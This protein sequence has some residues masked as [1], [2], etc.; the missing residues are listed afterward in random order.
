MTSDPKPFSLESAPAAGHGSLDPV[1]R[2][3]SSSQKAWSYHN[4]PDGK[5]EWLTPQHIIWQVGEGAL[6]VPFDLDPCAPIKRPW[7]MA[8]KHYTIEDNGLLKQ[9]EGRVWCNPPYNDIAAWAARCAEYGNAM[10]M[11]FA[12][13][14]T[15]WYHEYV[16]RA[17]D[18][19]AFLAGRVTFC[20]VNGQPAKWTGGGPSCLIAY[21]DCNVDALEIAIQDLELPAHLIYL[22]GNKR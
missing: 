9:W 22:E 20:H 5:D 15:R 10:M 19:V 8:K 11:T 2:P 12:R 18:A 14:E 3:P 4:Q 13:T 6:G 1:V 21:G 7:D 17:A 16:W